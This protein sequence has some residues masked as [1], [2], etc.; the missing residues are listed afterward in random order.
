MENA[1]V[2]KTHKSKGKLHEGSYAD[3]FVK[4][5]R[6]GLRLTTDQW[7]KRLKI[8]KAHFT[9]L[10]NNL[11]KNGYLIYPIGGKRKSFGKGMTQGIWVDILEIQEH[12]NEV[13][14]RSE[15]N[16]VKPATIQAFKNIEFYAIKHPEDVK[17]LRRIA[18]SLYKNL[19]EIGEPV[20]DS[21]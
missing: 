13:F 2:K 8:G 21:I 5:V 15:N 20:V 16:H 3:R 1:S 12:F 18:M 11:R 10:P 14:N 7:V 6:G 4:G 9:S 19:L 17:H